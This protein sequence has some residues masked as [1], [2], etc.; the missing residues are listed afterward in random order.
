MCSWLRDCGAKKS[1]AM[2]HLLSDDDIIELKLE[3]TF[4]FLSLRIELPLFS[5]N[6]IAAALHLVNV[7][8]W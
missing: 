5:V 4:A 6:H 7:L 2:E 3:T 1:G 8:C